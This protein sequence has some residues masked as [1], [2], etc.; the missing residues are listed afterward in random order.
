MSSNLRINGTGP[1][2]SVWQRDL[3]QPPNVIPVHNIGVTTLQS[4]SSDFY[5]QTPIWFLRRALAQCEA[6][7]TGEEKAKILELTSDKCTAVLP[8]EFALVFENY[9]KIVD[10]CQPHK[11]PLYLVTVVFSQ[12]AAGQWNFDRSTQEKILLKF[13]EL[14]KQGRIADSGHILE[15]IALGPKTQAAGVKSLANLLFEIYRMQRIYGRADLRFNLL[16][17]LLREPYFNDLSHPCNI[18][19][20]LKELMHLSTKNLQEPLRAALVCLVQV[21]PSPPL[22]LAYCVFEMQ[23]FYSRKEPASPLVPVGEKLDALN[24]KMAGDA[25]DSIACIVLREINSIQTHF[26]GA[27]VELSDAQIDFFIRCIEA[28]P[29]E[30]LSRVP[31]FI[32]ILVESPSF[33]FTWESLYQRIEEQQVKV[34]QIRELLSAIVQYHPGLPLPPSILQQLISAPLE[35]EA[36]SILLQLNFLPDKTFVS[37]LV[38][39]KQETSQSHWGLFAQDAPAA[40]HAMSFLAITTPLLFNRLIKKSPFPIAL[41]FE[42]TTIATVINHYLANFGPVTDPFVKLQTQR[43]WEKRRSEFVEVLQMVTSLLLNAPHP[44]LDI[45]QDLSNLLVSSTTY[46]CAL[47]GL[48]MI[49]VL[50]EKD[51]LPSPH[52]LTQVIALVKSVAMTYAARKTPKLL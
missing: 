17:Q 43:E 16:V 49:E 20:V 24:L 6:G 35:F 46:G 47:E 8:F 41:H 23:L 50:Q 25:I 45:M 12:M 21:A 11:I 28:L 27:P 37:K 1:A 13:F 14:G 29:V 10:L 33:P 44:P 39:C 18:Y 51:A 32:K 19:A 26:R 2:R 48:H 42:S 9:C 34:F 36:S 38:S 5:S 4:L 40:A 31:L 22:L 7:L 30:E 15:P 52:L 3:S